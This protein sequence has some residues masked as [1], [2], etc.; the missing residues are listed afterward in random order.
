MPLYRLD[1]SERCPANAGVMNI[2]D[3][4]KLTDWLIDGARSATTPT[5]M[6]SETCERLV[7][8][9]LPL[10]R[11]GVFIRMLH[12]D[13]FGRGFFWRPGSEVVVTAADFDIQDSPEYRN[14]PLAIL[15]GTEREVRFRLD[16]PASRGFPFLDDLRAEGVTD[17]IALPLWF[18]GEMHASSWSTKQPGGF[19]DR[20]L[21]A[22]R[23]LVPPL[24]RV[25]E[26]MSLS[27]K[28][29]TLLDTY[30]GN[31]AGER[32]LA[33]QIRRG[34]T[35]T[36]RAAIWLSDLRG[37]TALSDRLAPEIVVDISIATST[38]RCRQSASMA[39]RS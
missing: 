35:E 37:F 15:Y 38:A 27:R 4:Q 30:V 29:A 22:L 14:S 8:A 12:P 20:Q 36:M 33:G 6:M 23:S 19:S 2:S 11:V 10:W 32:I 39:A 13:V 26:I 16:D 25:I 17:Y 9:G 18:V 21:D 3:L 7:Q 24:A 31:R 28:A 34:H 1:V 5:R